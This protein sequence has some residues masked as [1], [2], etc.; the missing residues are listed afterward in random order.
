MERLGTRTKRRWLIVFDTWALVV[1]MSDDSSLILLQAG[2]GKLSA[3]GG[4]DGVELT[5][6]PG[7]TLVL[8]DSVRGRV[9]NRLWRRATRRCVANENI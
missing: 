4:G 9:A 2:V 5:A 7:S 6:E 8:N 1:D 3:R